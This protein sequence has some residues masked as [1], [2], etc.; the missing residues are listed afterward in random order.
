M[1]GKLRA[2]VV[3]TMR[4]A[5]R[6]ASASLARYHDGGWQRSVCVVVSS[7]ATRSATS[8][9]ATSTRRAISRLGPS[10]NN[11]IND[12]CYSSAKKSL[13]LPTTVPSV[14]LSGKARLFC[15]DSDGVPEP[16][17]DAQL[18]QDAIV[19]RAP[20]MSEHLATNGF[21]TCTDF[22]QK[23]TIELLRAQSTELRNKGRY[24]Q[25]WSE[26]VRDDGTVER[27]DKEGVYAC[28]PDGR[29]YYS[30]PDLITY[31]SV[32]LQTLPVVL[33]GQTPTAELELSNASFNAKLAVTSPGGSKYPLHI[34]NP[35]GLSVGDTRKLTCILYLNP[36]Y[37]GGEIRIFLKK[38]NTNDD[39]SDN[40]EGYAQPLTTVDLS[41]EGGRLL[42]F[43][44]DEIPHEVLATA[45]HANVDDERFDRYALTVWIP[46][47]NLRALHNEASKFSDLKDL[48]FP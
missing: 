17:I 21:Y 37:L 45:P 43:Y 26:K 14:K 46:S 44:S 8:K 25:S 10:A 41:P 30:A 27:F 16:T 13:P 9:A 35:Q 6:A 39:D 38:S 31:M 20:E 33:N 19:Q 22:L 47:E 36:E 12:Y 28:E 1:N 11:V 4:S 15:T 7:C 24:E 32:L 2:R 5:V 18:I 48:A 29:D 23:S 34:D 3:R 42:M 40:N